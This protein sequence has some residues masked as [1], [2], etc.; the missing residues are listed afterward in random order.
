ML[1]SSTHSIKQRKNTNIQYSGLQKLWAT[2]E[3]PSILAIPRDLKAIHKDGKI[4]GHYKK[5]IE[6]EH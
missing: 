5:G 1:A 3:A 6:K 4:R 2:R